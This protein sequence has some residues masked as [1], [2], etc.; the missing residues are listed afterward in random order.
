MEK[1]QKERTQLLYDRWL[2][3]EGKK[4][5]ERYVMLCVYVVEDRGRGG[6]H[7]MSYVYE[8]EGGTGKLPGVRFVREGG[9]SPCR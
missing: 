9:E 2:C 8:R 5:E 6:Y 4:G 1:M 3:G 7:M